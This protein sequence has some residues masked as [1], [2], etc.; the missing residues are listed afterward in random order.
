M[1]IG[2]TVRNLA[3]AAQK[4]ADLPSYGV[5]GFCLERTA[6][7]ALIEELAGRPAAERGSVPGIKPDRGDVI[8]AGAV[9][10]HA[11]LEAGG[12]DAIEVTEAGMREGVFFE[13][14]LDGL[15]PPLLG[16]V[17]EAS[18]YNLHGH[19]ETDP[20]HVEHVAH[21]ALAMFDDLAT[22][23]L[24][25]G[26]RA[27]RELLWAAA[28]LH[29][30]GMT[31]DYDDHH[32]HSRYLVLNA[33]L[34]GFSPREVGLIAQAVRYHRKGSPSLG[35]F[36]PLCGKGDEALLARMSALLRVAEQLERSRDQ[37]VRARAPGRGR[38]PGAPGAGGRRR[39]GG[40]ALGGRAPGRR[41]R[42]RV[43]APAGD[44]GLGPD[45]PH[46]HAGVRYS[47]ERDR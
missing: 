7:E 40:G 3:A 43:P 29:D 26:D 30:I 33:G 23:G 32:R 46:G 11:V 18:V 38:Q 10:V 36:A 2:G 19:Y 4:A 9:T 17:R 27:E 16:S 45:P 25:P 5:Q 1:G 13:W 6:L 8:L 12:F 22:A 24:H 44:R 31:V 34:P 35:E 42:R 41:L 20:T 39:R 14:Y 28:I 47:R 15:D 21:L 37:S